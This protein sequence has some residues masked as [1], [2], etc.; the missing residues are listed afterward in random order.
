MDFPTFGKVSLG[1]VT[2][3]SLNELE[4]TRLRRQKVGFIFQSFQLLAALS[5][6]EN[7]ELPLML[8]GR[9]DARSRALECLRWVEMERYEAR[10]PFQLSGGE[11]QRVGIAR[12]LAHSPSLLLADEPTGNL[13]T[14]TS[15]LILDILRRVSDEKNTTILKA[16]HRSEPA[17]PADTVIHIPARSMGDAWKITRLMRPQLG[18]FRLWE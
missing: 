1:G 17:G 6:V 5:V 15:A 9:K 10:R 14:G 7:V 3:S 11:M 16:P 4:L 13:D 8:A 2:T 18:R 12:A